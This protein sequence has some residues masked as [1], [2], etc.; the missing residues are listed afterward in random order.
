MILAYL[1]LGHLLGDFVLQPS[2]LV[3]WKMKNATGTLVHAVVH[4][5]V[6]TLLLIPFIIQG[7][8]W[9]IFIPIFLS[10]VHFWIDEMKINYDLHHDEKV[11]P[12]LIDQ[13][14]H[15][16]AILLV[17]FFIQDMVFTLPNNNFYAYFSDIRVINLLSF[18][19]FASTV[20]EIFRFQKKREHNKKARLKMQPNN[21]LK[22]VLIFTLVYMLFMLLGVYSFKYG[23]AKIFVS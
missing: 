14:L 15:L 12:F 6:T 9:L 7:Y 2:K 22:R 3:L 11:R 23:L 17:H 21:M 16:L 4:F 1:I 19:I 10:F 18:L 5:A 8:P 20:I 13:L